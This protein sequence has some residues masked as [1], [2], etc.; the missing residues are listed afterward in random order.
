M[1]RTWAKVPSSMILSFLTRKMVLVISNSLDHGRVIICVESSSGFTL[2]LMKRKLQGFTCMG[3]LQGSEYPRGMWEEIGAHHRLQE[4]GV[5][6]QLRVT[7]CALVIGL[8]AL[9]PCPTDICNHLHLW[10]NWVSSLLCGE[11]KAYKFSKMLATVIIEKP[12][13]GFGSVQGE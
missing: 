10:I 3:P 13:T 2:K 11:G 1:C 8:P 6:L 4:C 7:L 5:L 12:Y 9:P